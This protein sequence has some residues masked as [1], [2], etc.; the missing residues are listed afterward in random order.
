[1]LPSPISHL[2]NRATHHIQILL[3][4]LMA[5][6]L[7]AS[8]LTLG[9]TGPTQAAEFPSWDAGWAILGSIGRRHDRG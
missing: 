6:L 9:P 3:A 4:P 7:I 2:T 8:V 1:M 5:A